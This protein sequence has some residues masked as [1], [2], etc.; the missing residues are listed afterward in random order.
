[1]LD[2]VKALADSNALAII[3]AAAAELIIGGAW[4]S[5][6]LFDKQWGQAL[7]WS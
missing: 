7:G 3:V 4:E 1:M 6:A 5:P 2:F